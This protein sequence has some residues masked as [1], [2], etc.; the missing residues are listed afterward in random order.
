GRAGAARA[1]RGRPRRGPAAAM[2]VRVRGLQAAAHLNDMQGMCMGFDEEKGRWHVQ[3]ENGD[4]KA[5]K[6][7][8]F[9]PVMGSGGPD[10]TLEGGR[11]VHVPVGS[12]AHLSSTEN[13]DGELLREVLVRDLEHFCEHTGVSAELHILEARLLCHDD[14]YPSLAFVRVIDVDECCV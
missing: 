14:S 12:V 13:E 2:V 1:P 9:V 5:L 7:D 4:L 3:L 10:L 8:N 6:P 11:V